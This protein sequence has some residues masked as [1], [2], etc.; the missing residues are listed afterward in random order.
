MVSDIIPEDPEQR[1]LVV[2]Q[3]YPFRTGGRQTTDNARRQAHQETSRTVRSDGT[4]VKFMEDRSVVVRTSSIQLRLS[5]LWVLQ[6]E[7]AHKHQTAKRSFCPKL[8]APQFSA[9]N[10]VVCF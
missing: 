2:K 7:M 8:A 10:D 9:K 5:Y 1:K 6:G 3:S 4:V